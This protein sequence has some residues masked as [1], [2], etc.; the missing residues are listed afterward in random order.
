[1]NEYAENR[2]NGC[3]TNQHC[4]RNLT[5]LRLTGSEYFDHFADYRAALI[6][7]ETYGIYSISAKKEQSCPYWDCACRIYDK[8]PIECRL[9]PYT[10]GNFWKWRR[11][12]FITFHSRTE[13]PFKERLLIPQ[14]KAKK[15]VAEFTEKAFGNRCRQH[16]YNEVLLLG[17]IN[18][19]SSFFRRIIGTF[20]PPG[21]DG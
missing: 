17:L 13:C 1:M 14:G 9:Y 4:C 7:R 11:H 8:R 3:S 6:V 18:K 15:M 21:Q 5:S 12:I 19:I 10:I 2:C 16:V 20:F